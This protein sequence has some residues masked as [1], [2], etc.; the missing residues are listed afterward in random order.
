MEA[1][2]EVWKVLCKQE[3]GVDDIATALRRMHKMESR[4]DGAYRGTLERH[5]NQ[6][7]LMTVRSAVGS[8]L[9]SFCPAV[10]LPSA[11]TPIPS[12]RIHSIHAD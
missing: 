10:A 1:S 6:P 7:R 4:A 9:P 8:L 11:F 12:M 5:P 2:R 3:V